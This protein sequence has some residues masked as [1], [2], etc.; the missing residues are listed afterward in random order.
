MN[1]FWKD[2]IYRNAYF[3]IGAAW[4]FTLSFIFS[5]YWSYTSSPQG[6][7]KNLENYLQKKEQVFFDITKDSSLLRRLVYTKETEAE[8]RGLTD[9]DFGDIHL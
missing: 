7:R 3:L 1:K 9:K 6:V 8:M 2:T 5:N 4:L